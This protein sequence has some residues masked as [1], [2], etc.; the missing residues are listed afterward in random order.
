MKT[1]KK[2]AGPL[3]LFAFLALPL[4][5]ADLESPEFF[6]RLL[7]LPK[8]AGPQIFEDAVIFTA[9]SSHRRVGVALAAEGFAQVHW[10]RQLLLTQD[11]LDAPIPP[12]KK[13]PDPY[14]DSGLLFYVYQA[15]EGLEEIEYR[16]VIDGLWTTDPAN[17]V[18][19]R[20]GATGITNSLV[21]LPHVEKNRVLHEN[22]KGGMYFSFTG[23]PGELVTVAGSFNSWDPFMYE[24]R[25]YPEGT[26]TLS[27][28]LPPGTYQ[29]LFFHRGERFLDPYNFR[30]AYTREGNIASEVVIE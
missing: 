29:Y 23:P 30:R 27:L 26:Y 16:L 19:R 4:M 6:D 18:S 15:P 14:I 25:E 7:G 20:N 17:P 5:G 1:K 8:T 11:P 24:L 21:V 10:M 13:V 3:V 2:A 22:P 12:G 28:P 9:T